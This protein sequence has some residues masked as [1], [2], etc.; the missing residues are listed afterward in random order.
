MGIKGLLLDI[1]NTITRWEETH[2]PEAE[3]RWLKTMQD[4]GIQIRFISNGLHGKIRRV[5]KQTG[6]SHIQG[7]P[8]KPFPA[9]FRR[10]LQ[11]MSLEPGEALMVGDSAVTDIAIANRLKI[12]T[13]LVEPM[14]SVHFPGSRFWKIIERAFSLRYPATPQGEMRSRPG[15][16]RD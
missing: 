6:L 2:V 3:L 7:R 4:N 16:H 12:W 9:G 14:S 11:E 8:L 1:D 13:A 5:E 15:Q 10:G